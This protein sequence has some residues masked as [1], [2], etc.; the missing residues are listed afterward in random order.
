MHLALLVE[1]NTYEIASV[2]RFNNKNW[3]NKKLWW[4][5]LFSSIFYKYQQTQTNIYYV[6]AV[7]LTVT[8]TCIIVM[9]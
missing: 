6:T 2:R 1:K 3:S 8:C 7:L 4:Q 5:D 9:P